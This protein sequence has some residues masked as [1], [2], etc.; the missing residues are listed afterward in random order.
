MGKAAFRVSVEGSDKMITCLADE[1]LLKAMARQG[2]SNIP[3]G[4]RNGGCGVCKIRVTEGT[5]K[6]GKMSIKHVTQV[7][8]NDGY[9]LACKAFPKSDLTVTVKNE[10]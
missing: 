9:A 4:C 2:I 7:E 3:V 5:Y 8:R 10:E 6:T 1:T